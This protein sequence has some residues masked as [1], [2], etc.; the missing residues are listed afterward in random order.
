[1]LENNTSEQ[2]L[3]QLVLYVAERCEKHD[4]FGMV[5]LNKVLFFS[6]RNAYP[7]GD[8]G[9]LRVRA[10]ISGDRPRNRVPSARWATLFAATSSRGRTTGPR[11]P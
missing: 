7:V 9:A 11:A 2:K 10:L 1:M 5:K 6:D 8:H 4:L 3:T